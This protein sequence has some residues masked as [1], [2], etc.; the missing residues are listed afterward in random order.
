VEA[1]LERFEQSRQQRV[2]DPA[3]VADPQQYAARVAPIHLHPRL[4]AMGQRIADQVG[5][6]LAKAIQIALQPRVS[7]QVQ[8]DPVR[9]MRAARLGDYRARHVGQIAGTCLQPQAT[10]ADPRKIQQ[11]LDHPRHPQ[12]AGFQVLQGLLRACVVFRKLQRQLVGTN[13]RALTA[14]SL[15]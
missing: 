6:D 10:A 2:I 12:G 7:L 9:P 3:G 14:A 15:L 11:L 13:A 4:A 8:V 5:G 1:G